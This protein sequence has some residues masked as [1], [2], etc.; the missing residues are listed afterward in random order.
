MRFD[1]MLQLPRMIGR[2][3]G[4]KSVHKLAIPSQIQG[5]I[6]AEEGQTFCTTLHWA[7]VATLNQRMS[8]KLAA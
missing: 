8:M 6:P 2:Q 5:G 4:S 1:M 3:W 7:L